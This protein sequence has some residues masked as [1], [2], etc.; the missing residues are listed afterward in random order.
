L[1]AVYPPAGRDLWIA[2]NLF[3]FTDAIRRIDLGNGRVVTSSGDAVIFADILRMITRDAPR[4]TLLALAGVIVFVFLALRGGRATAHVVG[5]LV[6][7]VLW[8]V[9][10][11]AFGKVKINFFNFVAIP[12]TFGIA[13]D[14]TINIYARYRSSRATA[15]EARVREALLETGGAVLL[16]SVTTII[17]YATLIIA[18]NLALVSFGRLAILG[19]L[20]CV[21][22]ALLLLPATLLVDRRA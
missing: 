1:V 13:V 19:E 8:M 16:C 3:A 17:G 9:G 22:A 20:T 12:T 18:D 15:K 10:I 5:A 21:G 14:Y 4:T 2:D 7:G 6:I 11:A